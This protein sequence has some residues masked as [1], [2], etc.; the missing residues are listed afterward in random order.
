MNRKIFLV[1]FF[2]AALPVVA[3]TPTPAPPAAPA[4][5]EPAAESDAPPL[6]RP[7]EW[8]ALL[9][10]AA[11]EP[12]PA[13]PKPHL[14]PGNCQCGCVKSG[15][16]DCKDCDHPKGKDPTPP[17]PN[18][19]CGCV[20]TGQCYCKNCDNP[21]LEKPKEE[22]KGKPTKT[23]APAPASAPSLK[24]DAEV[25]PNGQYVNFLPDTDCVSVMFIGLDG[26]DPLPS[27]ILK[28][29]RMFVLDTRGMAQGR[30]RFAAVGANG[31][32]QQVR[33]DFA[34]VIGTPPAPAPPG[35][36]AP[37]DLTKT[38]QAAYDQDK[39]ADRAKSLAYLQSAYT[40]LAAGAK[41]QTFTTNAT[42]TAWVKAVVGDPKS[43]LTP[44]QIVNVRR[45]V[46]AELDAAWGKADGP[47]S[48]ADA[49]KE[50]ARID[51]A[52]SGVKP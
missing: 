48:Q 49:A 14:M 46:A 36:P 17:C 32:G 30:Y 28:D 37:S 10:V 19:Q 47:V 18:C 12:K 44:T 23:P 15:K 41:R 22:P 42:W 24:I 52:L 21:A 45:A 43:G 34:V 20:D 16:C 51:D 25:K 4:D 9:T 7:A 35:P 50:L 40:T 33:T 39:D 11:E 31:A 1:L 3:F 26:I 8:L 5:P 6:F 13:D 38:L 27:A 29:A 2:A